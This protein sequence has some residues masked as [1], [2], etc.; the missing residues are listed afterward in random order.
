MRILLG[1]IATSLFAF[2]GCDNGTT[3][4][5][6]PVYEASTVEAGVFMVSEAGVDAAVD[7]AAKDAT[8]EATAHDAMH[9]VGHDAI[10]PADAGHDATVPV[11]ASTD[12]GHDANM[13]VAV[14]APRG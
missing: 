6:I 13:D 7:G 4:S 10:G 1:V 2:T 12:A 9:D 11:D 14:D 8:P 3:P 5:P